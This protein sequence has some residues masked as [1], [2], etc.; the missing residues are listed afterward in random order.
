MMLT[1]DIINYVAAIAVVFLG[2]KLCRARLIGKKFAELKPL[3]YS[4]AIS[5]VIVWVINIYIGYVK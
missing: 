1:I 5:L 2:Y 4:F 3:K